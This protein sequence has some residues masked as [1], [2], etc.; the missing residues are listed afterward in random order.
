MLPVT[1]AWLHYDSIWYPIAVVLWFTF[2]QYLEANIIFPWVIGQRLKVN[3]LVS[4]IA[5]FVGGILWGASGMVLFLP[6]VAIL[7]IIAENTPEWKALDILLGLDKA[8]LD[9]RLRNYPWH[10]T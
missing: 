8:L 7:K 5:L 3:T 2:V 10:L 4:L 6:F 1:L 9:K